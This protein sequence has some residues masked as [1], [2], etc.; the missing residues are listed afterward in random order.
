MKTN[1]YQEDRRKKILSYL[2]EKQEATVDLLANL[3]NVT[4]ATIRT[5]LTSLTKQGKVIRTLGKAMLMPQGPLFPLSDRL[6]TM[7]A[8]KETIGKIAATL[9]NEGEIIALDASSTSLAL[10]K[11][12]KNL[13]NL[14]V[15]TNCLAVANEFIDKPLIKLIMPGGCLQHENAAITGMDAV[16][17]IANLRI[18]TSFI[19]A[20]SL[21]LDHGLGDS[22][23]PII[24]FKKSL[25]R[26]SKKVILLADSSK[27]GM[28]S[29]MS[30]ANFSE[31]NTLISDKDIPHE[32]RTK[33][34]QMGVSVITD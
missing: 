33:L 30:F 20:R 34:E 25:M 4:G 7:T 10:A 22:D 26:V 18:N 14:T 13:N 29:L 16:N 17:Y 19:G 3:F 28:L 27:W 8:A 2:S 23:Q 24:D 12:I 21:S 9:I 31:I 32:N 5:D 11:N 6:K 15:I 1:R